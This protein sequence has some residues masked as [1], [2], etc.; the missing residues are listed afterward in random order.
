MRALLLLVTACGRIGFD[1]RTAPV[2]SPAV[3]LC[4]A[5]PTALYCN[6]FD[7]GDLRGATGD[8]MFVRGAVGAGLRFAARPGEM[9]RLTVDLGRT[10][11]SGPLFLGAKFLL[12]D[13]PAI[14][15]FVVLGQLLAAAFVDKVSFDLVTLDRAQ[16]ANAT[17][18]TSSQGDPNTVPRGRWACFELAVIADRTGNGSLSLSIDNTTVVGGSTSDPTVGPDGFGKAELGAFAS[19]DNVASV[20]VVFD[21][22]VVD[23]QQIGCP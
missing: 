6:D 13:G 11:T 22:W 3:P 10:I 7:D 4:D 2:D 21:D 9:P 1:E 8:A 19:I 20:E 17:A 16:V 5:H 14:E 12:S 15:D 18:V 23:T